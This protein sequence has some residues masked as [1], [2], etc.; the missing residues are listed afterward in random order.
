MKK[1]SVSQNEYVSVIPARRAQKKDPS[2]LVEALGETCREVLAAS[3]KKNEPPL[4]AAE[5]LALARLQT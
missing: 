5:R 3:A 2:P 1:V 4:F